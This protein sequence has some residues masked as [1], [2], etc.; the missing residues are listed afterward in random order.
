LH[1]KI[2][3]RK[4]QGKGG[5]GMKKHSLSLIHMDWHTSD[6]NGKQVLIIMYD[7]SRKI[8]AGGEFNCIK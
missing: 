4:G 3:R 6:Y 8:L 2:K 5:S 1:L 7:S